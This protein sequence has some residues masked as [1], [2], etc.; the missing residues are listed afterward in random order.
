MKSCSINSKEILSNNPLGSLR[1]YFPI[2]NF[3]KATK[4][5]GNFENSYII[6]C[7]NKIFNQILAI[8]IRLKINIT[9]VILINVNS[10]KEAKMHC[11]LLDWRN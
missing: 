5:E 6:T 3:V 4:W 7:Y 8:K 2:S 1:K 10:M 9:S 11:D